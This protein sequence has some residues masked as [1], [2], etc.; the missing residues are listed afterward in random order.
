MKPPR[1]QAAALRELTNGEWPGNVRELEHTVQKL[2]L[3]ARGGDAGVDLVR[4]LMPPRNRVQDA[5]PAAPGGFPSLRQVEARHIQKTLEA[6]QGDR[7]EAARR[8][9]IGRA[10][11]YRK[12]KDFDLEVPQQTRRRRSRD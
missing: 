9:G 2:V 7:E 12:I 4:K 5:L 3:Y 1:L 6:C 8:L 11:V 10:T